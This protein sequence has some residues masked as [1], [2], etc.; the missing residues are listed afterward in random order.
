MFNLDRKPQT[1]PEVIE[2]L[3]LFHEGKE[4]I[5]YNE[6]IKWL[7]VNDQ[8]WDH[9]IG[10][11][12]LLC[13]A[14]VANRAG[15]NYLRKIY[16][17]AEAV[18]DIRVDQ[19]PA[20]FIIKANHDSGSVY[21]VTDKQSWRRAKRK[22]KRKL[23]RKFFGLTYGEWAYSYI[24]PRVFVEEMMQGPITDYKFHC[25]DGKICWVQI[26]YDRITKRPREV[27]V[28]E[29]YIPLGLH[30][31]QDFVFT[32]EP[33]QAPESWNQMKEVARLL[34]YGFRY[35]RVDLYNYLGKPS[36]GELTFWPKAGAYRTGDEREFGNLL[37]INT[38]FR[39]P[40]IHNFFT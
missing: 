36:F 30:M 33:P 34:S 31:D 35:V 27:N 22:L 7:M 3:R 15:Q 13:R 11:D 6:K 40:M 37:N 10:C 21:R 18:H 19:L 26:I 14:I 24:R 25:C 1:P 39:R 5:G 12:K 20:S 23:R 28:D 38:S 17:M 8:M 4:P 16:D 2:Q 9:V 29:D 32:R